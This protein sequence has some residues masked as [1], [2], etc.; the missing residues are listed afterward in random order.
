[1]SKKIQYVCYVGEDIKDVTTNLDSAKKFYKT[2]PSG[3]GKR[4]SLR[5]SLIKETVILEDE[6]V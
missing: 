6:R 1:M 4:P 5:R 3:K 2:L